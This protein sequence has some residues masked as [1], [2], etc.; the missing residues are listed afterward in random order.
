[1]NLLRH[2]AIEL[3]SLIVLASVLWGCQTPSAQSDGAEGDAPSHASDDRPAF[4]GCKLVGRARNTAEFACPKLLVLIKGP[5]KAYADGRSALSAL[6]QLLRRAKPPVRNTHIE[7]T[8]AELA[9]RTVPL[10]AWRRIASDETVYAQ[11]AAWEAENKLVQCLT[12]SKESQSRCRQIFEAL[13]SN[14]LPE[15][16][17]EALA[18]AVQPARAVWAGQELSVPDGCHVADPTQ[19]VCEHASLTFFSSKG[20]AESDREKRRIQQLEALVR[21]RA[22]SVDFDP[23]AC[24]LQ[25][26]TGHCTVT[27]ANQFGDEDFVFWFGHGRLRDHNVSFVCRYRAGLYTDLP[28]LCRQ[29]IT[30]HAA[31]ESDPGQ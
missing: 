9:Q 18:P 7:T 22:P 4:E 24:Q 16:L 14:G 27:K 1:M 6:E 29:I 11:V 25:G 30:S 26:Q 15:H 21:R 23:T 5:Q 31:D 28:P 19:L 12:V 20:G 3:I 13:V 8:G 2:N 17:E 10:L